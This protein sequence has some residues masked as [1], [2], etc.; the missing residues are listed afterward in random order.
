MENGGTGTYSGATFAVGSGAAGATGHSLGGENKTKTCSKPF[1]AK[2]LHV[3][4]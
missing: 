3:F 1:T 2:T 4:L